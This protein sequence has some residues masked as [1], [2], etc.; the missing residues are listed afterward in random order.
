MKSNRTL[1]I[2]F[3]L[4]IQ[5]YA[6]ERVPSDKTE[7]AITGIILSLQSDATIT[8]FQDGEE[9]GTVR[10]PAGN[11]AFKIPLTDGGVYDIRIIKGTQEFPIFIYGIQ[12]EKGKEKSLGVIDSPRTPN[13]GIIHGEIDNPAE[14]TQ[15][16]V[17]RD[18]EEKVS[19]NVNQDGTFEIKNLEYG[20]Y[21]VRV[22]SK[23][24]YPDHSFQGIIL[25]DTSQ[26][27][28][29]KALLLYKS[30]ADSVNWDDGSIFAKG[31]GKPP[32]NSLNSAQARIMAERAAMVDGHRNLLSVMQGVK[33][34]PQT[35]IDDLMNEEIIPIAKV[36]GFVKGAS[37]V[38]KRYFDDGS[39]EV[40]LVIPLT[41]ENGIS[42]FVR[43]NR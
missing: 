9:Q 3:A 28:E 30:E 7:T 36:E 10:V 18:R 29:L 16:T 21:N 32:Q 23:G 12:V 6:C 15:I 40:I 39:C 24:Y 27:M 4:C 20:T 19:I 14:D 5:F 43:M 2:L 38:S 41:G 37:I 13:E 17:Y 34:D 35:K 22:T 25:S 8:I 26:S 42:E 11:G 33:I 31:V 1:I